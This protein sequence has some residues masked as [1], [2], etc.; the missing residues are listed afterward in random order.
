M[1]RYPRRWF[2]PRLHDESI[3][4]TPVG[5]YQSARYVYHTQTGNM[6][7]EVQLHGPVR[8]EQGP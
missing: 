4:A 2:Y 3:P 8:Q 7:R 5:R 6:I 1:L